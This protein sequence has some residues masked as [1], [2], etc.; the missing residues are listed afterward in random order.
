MSGVTDR[1]GVQT[2]FNYSNGYLVW[3]PSYPS[4]G[5]E[6]GSTSE[7]QA[8]EQ[9]LFN[10][11]DAVGRVGER[12]DG[13]DSNNNWIE[14]TFTYWDASYW[15][16]GCRAPDAAPDNNPCEIWISRRQS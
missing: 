12:D 2:T 14:R 4:L 8:G 11:I 16:D 9:H 15:G 10:N 6:N 7:N 5:Y 3:S 13:L 1:R